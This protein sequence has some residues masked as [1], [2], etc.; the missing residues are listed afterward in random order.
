MIERQQ[1]FVFE[2]M[3][4]ISSQQFA[5]GVLIRRFWIS[6]KRSGLV[7]S[8]RRTYFQGS[9]PDRRLERLILG[10]HERPKPN[11]TATLAL[12]TNTIDVVRRARSDFIDIPLRDLA[13]S[14]G[15]P[16]T[17]RGREIPGESSL[18]STYRQYGFDDVPTGWRISVLGLDGVTQAQAVDFQQRLS[19]AALGRRARPHVMLTSVA[20]V[21]SR[22]VE[23]D[24]S[25][26]SP[27]HGSLVLILLPRRS[28][29]PTE[30][31]LDVIADLDRTGVP[32]RR[33]YVDDPLDF[34]LPDQLPSLLMAAGGR[35]HAIRV[36]HRFPG[37]LTVGI[38]LSHPTN[39]LASR[40]AATIVDQ[41]GMLVWATRME[42]R[43][44]ETIN[45]SI[46]QKLGETVR[47]WLRDH[48]GLDTSLIVLRDGRIPERELISQW[49]DCFG[50]NLAVIEVRKR[51]NPVLFADKTTEMPKPYAV[52]IENSNTVLAAAT[53]PHDLSAITEPLKLTWTDEANPIGLTPA[54]VANH[55]LTHCRAPGLGLHAHRLPSAIYWADGIAA[56]DDVDLRFRGIPLA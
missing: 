27:L 33:A 50:R 52:Q 37:A 15:C 3:R 44:D 54:E 25:G 53:A 35:P 31:A 40:L 42:V 11:R 20:G 2:D 49:M 24:A 55:V 14:H 38:D 28:T 45:A 36:T 1:V 5:D 34:S 43:R 48:G 23:L 17:I 51:G 18:N 29:P 21:R 10:T 22:L 56:S 47:T 8:P 13:A 41:A 46:M 39:G 32:F 7:A 12:L 19:A 4:S 26:K 16:I 9:Q 30:L 6:P